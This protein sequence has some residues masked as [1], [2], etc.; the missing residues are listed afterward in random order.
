MVCPRL[1]LSYREARDELPLFEGLRQYHLARLQDG[2]R[3]TWPEVEEQ[4]I[5]A[6]D[7]ELN[8]AFTGSPL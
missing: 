4:E 8:A 6:L 7:R 3:L 1:G 5:A 2:Q